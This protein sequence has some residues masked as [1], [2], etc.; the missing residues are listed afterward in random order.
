MSEVLDQTPV[1]ISSR[2]AKRIGEIL[3]GE[4]KGTMLRISITG[5][6]CSGFSYSFTFDDTRAGDDLFIESDKAKLLIDEVSLEYMR[7]AEVDF[8]DDLIGQSFKINNP[9]A[10]SSCGCG[11]SFSV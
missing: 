6:G 4:P 9:L 7:G 11:T 3:A 1:T 5:G 10:K 8:A 2:A